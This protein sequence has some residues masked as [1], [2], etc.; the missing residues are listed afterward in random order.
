MA[1]V[2]LDGVV[3]HYASVVALDTL[4]LEVR[5]GEFITLLGPSGCGKTTTLRMIAG[6]VEPTAG[7]IRLGDDDVTS[8]PPQR[9]AIGMVFQNYALFPHL[10][11]EENIG[12]ALKQRSVPREKIAR[13][14]REL[15]ELIRLPDVA[16]RYPSEISGGQQ[17]RVALA[18]AV[19][20]P[21]RVLLMDEP[22]G[23]LDLKLR[24]S[25]QAEIRR[26]QQEL[27][28]T[29]VYVTHD[30]TE[31]MTISDRIA[32]MNLGKLE[33]LGTSRE[34]YE[35]PRTIFVADFV[36]KINL[37]PARVVERGQRGIVV[38]T[39]LGRLLAPDANVG[40]GTHVTI[41]VRPQHVAL[42]EKDAP[43]QCANAVA[44]RIASHS[45]S[46][47]L[48]FVVVAIDDNTQILVET[49]ADRRV[50]G[51]GSPIAIGWEPAQSL[52]LTR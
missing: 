27:N 3:K 48:M 40:D 11:I 46:G 28:I 23:A 21:P 1:S 47:N 5:D 44:G 38:E 17:Q 35:S 26:F 31:A 32:V 25:M 52:V 10:T 16:R 29:T 7:R 33:Q 9:R 12:F 2:R 14:V 37:I 4:D 50:G 15:L 24:E 45:Y 8:V 6:F 42:M 20:Y 36:G 34:I 39:G 49:G 19:A 43:R 30:Q 22:L 18:R 51:I 13:R 41:G